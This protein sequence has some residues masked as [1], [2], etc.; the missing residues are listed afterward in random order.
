MIKRIRLLLIACP[1]WAWAALVQGME[2]SED[3]WRREQKPHLSRVASIILLQTNQL[4]QAQGLLPVYSQPDLTAAAEYFAHYM[5]RTNRYGHGADGRQPSE[6]VSRQGYDYCILMENIASQQSLGEVTAAQLARE[7]IEGWQRSDEHRENI[8]DPDV[9]DIG[10]A[11]AYS[12]ETGAYFAVQMLG[13]P[14]YTALEFSVSNETSSDLQ[15]TIA[16]K[17]SGK[18][19]FLAPGATRFHRQCRPSRLQFMTASTR[20]GLNTVFS[21]GAYFI[22]YEGEDGALQIQTPPL[23]GEG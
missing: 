8:L 9:I 10:V 17:S 3:P 19:F 21:H 1:L 6:R 4:R 12:Q 15:Y 23:A 16:Q 11:V 7:F 5:A 22:V 2:S 13:R 14:R 18:H 20:K